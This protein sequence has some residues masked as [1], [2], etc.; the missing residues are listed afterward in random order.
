[1]HCGKTCHP[2]TD[3]PFSITLPVGD[4]AKADSSNQ[5]LFEK[6]R[7]KLPTPPTDWKRISV[8]RKGDQIFLTLDPVLRERDP[9]WSDHPPLRFF[10]ADGQVDSDENQTV[11]VSPEGVVVMTL[12]AST[13]GPKSPTSLPGVVEI[14]AGK[15][16]RSIEINPEY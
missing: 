8:E 6:F 2:A 7:A 10:T 5:P 3:Q 11:Q 4:A 9:L 16:P 13:T 12:P 1:M 14:P 15:A